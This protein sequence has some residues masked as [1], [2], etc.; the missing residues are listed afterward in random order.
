MSAFTF[1]SAPFLFHVIMESPAIIAFALFP[2][3]T[4]RSRQ[5]DAHAVIRQYALLLLTTVFIAAFFAFQ[6]HDMQG[7]S[8]QAQKLE[9]QVAGALALYHMGPMTRAAGKIRD[10]ENRGHRLMTIVH[11]LTHGACGMTLAGRA[12]HIW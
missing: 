10:W 12:C 9:R 3:A 2:S 11:L 4:L 7:S 5:P 1:A 6:S 8:V